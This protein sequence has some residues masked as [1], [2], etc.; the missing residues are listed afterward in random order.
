MKRYG[1]YR[2]PVW[3]PFRA[4]TEIRPSWE[5]PVWIEAA[6]A[7]GVELGAAVH[8]A[9]ILRDRNAEQEARQ[10]RTDS[11]RTEHGGETGTQCPRI[12]DSLTLGIGP[13]VS[14]PRLRYVG[15]RRV[16]ARLVDQRGIRDRNALR[17]PA[18][19]QQ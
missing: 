15:R 18:T 10:G 4:H 13:R 6:R 17:D 7:D 9:A 8:G 11:R 14:W 3:G 5:G 16:R 1:S 12:R 19:R 2:Y